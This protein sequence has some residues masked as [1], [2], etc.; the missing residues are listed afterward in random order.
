[1]TR[2]ERAQ[3]ELEE[4]EK[5]SEQYLNKVQEDSKRLFSTVRARE[6]YTLYCALKEAGMS[7][8]NAGFAIH[9]Y[10]V[11]K[12]PDSEVDKE[13]DEEWRKYQKEFEAINAKRNR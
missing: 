4:Q 1:M 12:S 5:R 8:E 9:G 3:K 11:G 2:Q 6:A 10:L 13:G 7:E